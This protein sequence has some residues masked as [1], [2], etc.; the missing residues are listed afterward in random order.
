M[1]R[2]I[3]RMILYC[4]LPTSSIT[5]TCVHRLVVS[6][7][8]IWNQWL[9]QV[10]FNITYSLIAIW[11]LSITYWR[12][13]YHIIAQQWYHY[14]IKSSWIWYFSVNVLPCILVRLYL[15]TPYVKRKE[16]HKSVKAGNSG[17][18][19]LS[20]PLLYKC[21]K[22]ISFQI[23]SLLILKN[24]HNWPTFTFDDFKYEEIYI[25]L[26]CCSHGD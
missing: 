3:D 15:I 6:A 25:I 26:M 17:Q 4:I 20:L 14:V 7:S 22:I 5:Y 8:S 24:K 11:W 10:F 2:G 16:T 19:T 23:E 13:V 9:P 18:R 1:N 12:D 21:S